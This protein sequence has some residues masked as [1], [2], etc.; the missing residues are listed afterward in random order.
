MSVILE[1]H[2][3]LKKKQLKIA[4][5]ARKKLLFCLLSEK[6]LIHL[7]AE[8]LRDILCLTYCCAII[9][10]KKMVRHERNYKENY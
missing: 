9:G 5:F 10:F 4:A 3:W 7:R 2:S 8:S 6:H 1:K